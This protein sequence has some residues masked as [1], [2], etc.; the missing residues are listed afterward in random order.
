M[1]STAT[2]PEVNWSEFQWKRGQWPASEDI[3]G[4]VP[5]PH[6]VES[7]PSSI[8]A[9]TGI[10]SVQQS[11]YYLFYGKQMFC[12]QCANLAITFVFEKTCW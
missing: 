1:L 5:L 9:G 10:Y 2:T 12:K 7:R 11:A 8:T 6:L 4:T 3:S